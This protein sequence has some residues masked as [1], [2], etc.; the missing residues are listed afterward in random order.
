MTRIPSSRVSSDKRDRRCREVRH[1]IVEGSTTTDTHDNRLVCMVQSDIE[2][3][4][5][6]SFRWEHFHVRVVQIQL[7]KDYCTIHIKRILRKA[8]VKVF[9]LIEV[10]P[11]CSLC[12]FGESYICTQLFDCELSNIIIGKSN[13]FVRQLIHDAGMRC[14]RRPRFIHCPFAYIANTL[15]CPI[16][17]DVVNS[18]EVLKPCSQKNLVELCNGQLPWVLLD[19]LFRPWTTCTSVADAAAFDVGF[20]L[21]LHFVNSASVSIVVHSRLLGECREVFRNLRTEEFIVEQ[22]ALVSSISQINSRYYCEPVEFI[23]R[24]TI[25]I[26]ECVGVHLELGINTGKRHS[27]YTLNL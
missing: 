13:S 21:G 19:L 4:L 5:K 11:V 6:W 10:A 24:S 12:V 1:D 14:N 18:I 9:Q 26:A 17:S 16:A 25:L 8:T 22:L 27:I 3:G 7:S 20:N 23:S 15:L 2:Q